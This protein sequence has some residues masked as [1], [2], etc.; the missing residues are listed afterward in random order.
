MGIPG[1]PNRVFHP[2]SVSLSVPELFSQHLLPSGQERMRDMQFIS[3]KEE[4]TF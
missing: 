3:R 1:L 2:K 4:E